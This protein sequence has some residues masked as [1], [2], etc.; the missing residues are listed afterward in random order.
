[1]LMLM[2]MIMIMLMF[3]MMSATVSLSVRLKV[4]SRHKLLSDEQACKLSPDVGH[5]LNHGKRDA[6]VDQLTK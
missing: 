6:G 2:M 4:I 3:L 5:D 1:M